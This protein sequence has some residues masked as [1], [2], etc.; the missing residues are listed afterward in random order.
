M[1]LAADGSTA[2][3]LRSLL[4]QEPDSLFHSLSSRSKSYITA[5]RVYVHNDRTLNEQ[6]QSKVEKKIGYAVGELL[7]FKNNYKAAIKINEWVSNQTD[8]K[9]QNLVDPDGITGDTRVIL[10]NA[11]YFKGVWKNK[12][13][14]DDSFKGDFYINEKDT[15][16]MDYM[17]LKTDFRYNEFK[18]LDANCVEL[19]Y[20][21][22]NVAMYVILPRKRTGLKELLE[23]FSQIDFHKDIVENLIEQKVEVTLPRF[24]TEFSTNLNSAL[25]KMGAKTIF[26]SSADF[27][28]LLNTPEPIELSDVIHKAVLEVNEEGVIAAAATE[29]HL[30]SRC[31]PICEFLVAEHPFLYVIYDRIAK[32]MLF[33]GEF[34]S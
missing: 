33:M 5:N 31:A 34:H 26:S 20:Q 10:V 14:Q 22:E 19:P 23:K 12:F 25:R 17:Q 7:D 21:D 3:E 16:E 30:V 24:K 32:Q 8:Q 27:H 18:D 9:I 15:K 11:M 29:E 1:A 4:G 6:F 13:P 28:H 2:T